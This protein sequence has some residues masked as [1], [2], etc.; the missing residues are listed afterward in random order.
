LCQSS[1]AVTVIYTKF[2]LSVKFYTE[3]YNLNSCFFTNKSIYGN[4]VIIDFFLHCYLIEALEVIET[5]PLISRRFNMAN[6][7]Y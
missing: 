4:S 2:L 5:I 3:L 7:Q 6:I 1:H